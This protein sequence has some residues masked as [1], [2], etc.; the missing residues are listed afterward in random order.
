MN[1]QKF[2]TMNE[3]EFDILLV[4]NL[5]DVPPDNIVAGVTPWKRA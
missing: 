4:E 2:R 3:N 5:L 1:N